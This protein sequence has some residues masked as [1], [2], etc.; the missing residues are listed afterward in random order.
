MPNKKFKN[1]KYIKDPHKLAI[2]YQK[3]NLHYMTR[4]EALFEAILKILSINYIPQHII[5]TE[6][7]FFILDF[8]LPDL[9]IC[10]EIDG[11]DHKQ[12]T[13]Y[14]KRRE[15]FCFDVY[16]IDTYRITNKELKNNFVETFKKTYHILK[17]ENEHIDEK[18]E[19]SILEMLEK[20][21]IILN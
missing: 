16:K 15:S 11:E 4:H 2:K 7:S 14:D 12:N 1:K 6:H 18:I 19:Y 10:F 20:S 8:Y 3:H 9:N 21:G 13:L 17:D 5:M